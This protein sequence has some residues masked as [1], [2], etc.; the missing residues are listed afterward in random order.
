MLRTACA[1]A[2]TSRTELDSPAWAVTALGP[3]ADGFGRG[4]A[5]TGVWASNG[6]FPMEFGN[7]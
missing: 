2:G 3:L 1:A 4:T 6:A 5:C 7:A